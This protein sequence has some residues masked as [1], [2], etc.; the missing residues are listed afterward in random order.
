MGDLELGSNVV[1]RAGCVIPVDGVVTDGEAM[2][3][4]SVMTGESQS[5]HRVK[6][7]SVYA[8]TVVE[9]GSLVVRTTAF[10]NETRLRKIAELIDESESLKAD[11]QN[12]AERMADAIVPYSFLL[13]GGIFLLTGSAQ[14][15]TTALMVD[16]SC[17]IKL[18][19]PLA[20][21]SAMREGVRHGVLIKGGKFLEALST[22]DTI[23]FDKTGTL[24][25]ATPRVARVIPLG[26]YS[27]G[28]VL[29]TAAC[30]EEHF[31]HSIARAVVR[32][33]ELENLA[34]RE[35]HSKVEYAVAHGIA[36]RLA[37]E[38][39]LIGSA[40]FV[41]EDER[42]PISGEQQAAYREAA[43]R[44]S[45]L[46]LAIGP[47]LAGLICVEDPLRDGC[48]EILRDLRT[49]GFKRQIMLTGD[50][51]HVA[52]E[53]AARV[54]IDEAM[55]QLLPADKTR[56][57]QEMRAQ[58]ARV[59]MVGDGVNDSPALSA[60][61]VGIAMRGGADI[62][63]EVADVVLS[64]NRLSGLLDARRLSIGVMRKIRS[65]YRFIVGANSLL[66]LLG[67]MGVITPAASALLH[68]LATV[69]STLYSLR[70]ILGEAADG[71]KETRRVT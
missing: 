32:Q 7:D 54:G 58:G 30:L 10:D 43:G 21:L 65:N 55:A 71:P 13:A 11:V 64:D 9:A 24:T 42:I 4:Q 56:Y 29:R 28:E 26:E 53:V 33:A 57:V 52:D 19:T 67:L 59:V 18:S 17:A 37:G 60:A 20:I 68:N 23:V 5:V 12:R 35:E 69:S 15:A 36:S 27:R 3:N 40:H 39:V 47:R 46:C 63:R 1:I 51:R 25:V 66:L 8:G 38:K 16:Y 70:P 61:N 45:V 22:A 41:L 44:Y 49:Q 50:N 34:H 62:A 48:A 31:P 6:N 2:V 14:R